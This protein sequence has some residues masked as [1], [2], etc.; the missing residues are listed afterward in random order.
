MSRFRTPQTRWSIAELDLRRA[1]DLD[2]GYADAWA[3][4]GAVVFNRATARA[5]DRTDAE[6]RSVER[7]D[8]KALE[9][10]Q[11]QT[12]ARAVLAAFA[13]QYDWDWATAERELRSATQGPPSPTA[14]TYYAFLLSMRGNFA[15]A[16]RFLN[17]ALELDPLGFATLNQLASIRYYEHR[18][19]EALAAS[20]K[21]AA[22]NQVPR[23]GVAGCILLIEEGRADQALKEALELEEAHMP[24]GAI[25][26][27][28]A[29]ARLGRRDE[30]RLS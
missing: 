27:A 30:A 15:A 18:Y 3:R 5:G 21:I 12:A 14:L 24:T 6:R 9:L 4:L 20:D 8:R 22:I 13:L 17:R 19:A 16:D 7:Y 28:M 23:Q 11:G 10:D 2:P 26:E 29:L 25:A 1:L